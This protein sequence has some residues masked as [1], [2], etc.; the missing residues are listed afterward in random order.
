MTDQEDRV[1]RLE[2]TVAHQARVIEEL[3]DQIT[4]QWK[5]VEQARAKLDRLT[6]RFCRSRS[7]HWK[8]LPSPGRRTIERLF[9]SGFPFYDRRDD[10]LDLVLAHVQPAGQQSVPGKAREQLDQQCGIDVR[11][12]LSARLSSLEDSPALPTPGRGIVLQRL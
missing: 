8:R 10:L 7:S 6:E 12:H 5:V 1:L 4:E 3:S 11:S 2:E 9:S